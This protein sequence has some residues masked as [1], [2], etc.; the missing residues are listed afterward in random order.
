MGNLLEILRRPS[1]THKG[2][3]L[4]VKAEQDIRT[5]CS[6]RKIALALNTIWRKIAKKLTVS[7][8][9]ILLINICHPNILHKGRIKSCKY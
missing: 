7:H 3:H 1:C 8:P 9:N 4:Q 5:Q 2:L 6:S